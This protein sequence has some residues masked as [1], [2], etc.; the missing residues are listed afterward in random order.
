M[1][2]QLKGDLMGREVISTDS[3]TWLPTPL[4]IEWVFEAPLCIAAG[5]RAV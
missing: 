2:P 5:Q 4:M 3:F 1:F